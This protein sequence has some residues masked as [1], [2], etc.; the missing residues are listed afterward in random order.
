MVAVHDAQITAPVGLLREK[1]VTLLHP[2]SGAGGYSPTATVF[3]Y[4][5]QLVA[6]GDID[7]ASLVTHRLTGI[8]KLPEAIE[9]TRD[10]RRYGAI[11]PAQ[12]TIGARW[13]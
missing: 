6:R 1:S 4:S 13:P 3:E 9:M 8:D 2:L 7:L 11:N 5:M 10:K 12:V